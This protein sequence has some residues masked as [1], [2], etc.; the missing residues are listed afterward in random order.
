MRVRHVG[1]AHQLR[2][3]RGHRIDIVVGEH[4][5]DVGI[6][7]VH[8]LDVT[9]GQAHALQRPRQEIVRDAELHEID[10][11]PRNVG[12]VV[13]ALEHDAVVAVG[14]VVDDQCSGVHAAGRGQGE[15]VHVGH[16]AAVDVA[17]GVLVDRLDIVVDLHQVDADVVLVGP[18]VEDAA[19]IGIAPRHPAGIDRPA[20]AEAVARAAGRAGLAQW[21]QRERANEHEAGEWG[22]TG[23]GGHEASGFG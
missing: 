20:H 17:R 3:P 12:Q 23:T 14:I 5:D 2:V 21:G 19:G 13:A 6:G 18:L 11:A 4:A 22:D 9:F 15:R 10:L 7:G 16:R 1:D 8:R